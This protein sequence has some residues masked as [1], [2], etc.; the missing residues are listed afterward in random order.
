[1]K[2]EVYTKDQRRKIQEILTVRQDE[3]EF[4]EVTV[5]HRTVQKLFICKQ[6]PM[7][8]YLVRIFLHFRMRKVANLTSKQLRTNV[9]TDINK[10]H[11][12]RSK[13]QFQDKI[14]M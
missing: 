10:S 6:T 3:E 4:L 1:M 14:L 12:S 9:K 8:K 13:Y 7:E 2:R 11:S 5:S